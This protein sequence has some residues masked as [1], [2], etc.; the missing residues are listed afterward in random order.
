[1]PQPL[2]ANMIPCVDISNFLKVKNIYLMTFSVTRWDKLDD[3]L[4]FEHAKGRYFC[5]F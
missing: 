2:S 1:M 5:A 3:T 4:A